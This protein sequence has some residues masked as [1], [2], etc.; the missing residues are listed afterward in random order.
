[1][2]D[3]RMFKCMVQ[4]VNALNDTDQHIGY[5]APAKAPAKAPGGYQVS[6]KME[7]RTLL[8]AQGEKAAKSIIDVTNHIAGGHWPVAGVM[9]VRGLVAA[10]NTELT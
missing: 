6:A 3:G 4:N 2:K 5:Q 10:G 1:M 8:H 7:A 9:T